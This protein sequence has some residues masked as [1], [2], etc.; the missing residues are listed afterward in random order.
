[1][2]SEVQVQY[3]EPAVGLTPGDLVELGND[4]QAAG[5]VEARALIAE[6]QQLGVQMALATA[7]RILEH[8][9]KTQ[10]ARVRQMLYEVRL[11]PT[12]MAHVS[13]DQVLRIIQSVATSTPRS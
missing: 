12:F 2:S 6:M 10:E 8:I 3:L 5:V 1:M 9:R 13:R 11:L 4:L 7:P